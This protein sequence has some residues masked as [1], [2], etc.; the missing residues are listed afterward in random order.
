MSDFSV[1]SPAIESSPAD[2]TMMQRAQGRHKIPPFVE[3]VKHILN[4]LLGNI[5]P[6]TM[7]AGNG[8]EVSLP[9]AADFAD[10]EK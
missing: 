8:G 1:K 9:N 2:L 10:E 6:F 5:F 7:G 4:N 3:K